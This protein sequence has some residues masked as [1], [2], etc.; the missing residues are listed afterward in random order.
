MSQ[1]TLRTRRP[2]T[3]SR[4]GR[5]VGWALV[6]LGVV[7]ALP[8]GAVFALITNLVPL[9]AVVPKTIRV[10]GPVQADVRAVLSFGGAFLVAL[11]AIAEGAHRVARGAWSAKLFAAMVL[12]GSAGLAAIALAR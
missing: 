2:R 12:L 8:T 9:A 10:T 4:A 7:A 6:V 5:R 1:V 3:G 11:V